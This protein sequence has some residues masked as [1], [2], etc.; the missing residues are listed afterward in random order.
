MK[1]FHQTGADEVKEA[2]VWSLGIEYSGPCSLVASESW[3]SG[4]SA[5]DL[6]QKQSKVNYKQN[7]LA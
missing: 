7:H 3:A 1:G 2:N 6:I 4:S 5:P